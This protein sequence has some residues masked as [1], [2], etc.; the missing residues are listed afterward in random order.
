M[1]RIIAALLI[2]LTCS[3]G[4]GATHGADA[5]DPGAEVDFANRVNAFFTWAICAAGS[6]SGPVTLSVPGRKRFA[7][8]V[9]IPSCLIF[10]AAASK[11][12]SLS[13]AISVADS[14]T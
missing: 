9:A 14:S 3:V 7:A 6:M 12:A 8:G 13:V 1:R 4:L 2:A 10:A 11:S 5:A